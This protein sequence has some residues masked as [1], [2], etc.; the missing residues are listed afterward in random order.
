MLSSRRNFLGLLTFIG[1]WAALQLYPAFFRWV[2][3]GDAKSW[4]IFMRYLH[5]MGKET[6]AI[7][8][9]YL[10]LYPEENDQ[11]VLSNRLPDFK[12]SVLRSRLKLVIREDFK[13]GQ[14]IQLGGWT[15]SITEARLCALAAVL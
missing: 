11:R 13:S 15:L 1:A 3:G 8:R 7:G 9:E 12:T 5:P 2:Y 4:I 6:K 14:L 10:R